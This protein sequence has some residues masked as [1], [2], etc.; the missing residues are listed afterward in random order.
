[1]PEAENRPGDAAGQPERA[2]ADD[3]PKGANPDTGEAPDHDQETA[4][5]NGKKTPP[6]YPPE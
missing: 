1:M 5:D 3:D 6:E 2:H 4:A